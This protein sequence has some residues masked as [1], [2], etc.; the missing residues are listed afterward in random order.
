MRCDTSN[1]LLAFWFA[2]YLLRRNRMSR[3]QRKRSFSPQDLRRIAKEL[4]GQAN[5][6]DGLAKQITSKGLSSV[7]IDGAS[8][9]KSALTAL[10]VFVVRTRS[11]IEEAA[12]LGSRA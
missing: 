12:T 7:A 10:A 4:R 11:Q 3:E 1:C 2:G 8:K 6:L 5:E 9:Y